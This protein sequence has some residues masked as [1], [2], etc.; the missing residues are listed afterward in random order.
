MYINLTKMYYKHDIEVEAN[1]F[2]YYHNKQTI[3]ANDIT[4]VKRLRWNLNSLFSLYKLATMNVGCNIYF[5][6]DNI[7]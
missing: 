5:H 3:Q 6:Y 7:I 2:L 1:S 4:L